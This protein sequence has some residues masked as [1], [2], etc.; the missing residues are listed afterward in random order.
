M[1]FQ[2]LPLIFLSVCILNGLLTF[3]AIPFF[4]SNR[5]SRLYFWVICNILFSIGSATIAIQLI[6]TP[7]LMAFDI[8]NP[9]IAIAQMMR[10]LSVVILAFILRSFLPRASQ[11]ISTIKMFLIILGIIIFSISVTYPNIAAE[12][13]GSILPNLGAVALG[14]WCLYQINLIKKSGL[15]QNSYSLRILWVTACGFVALPFLVLVM[16][17]ITYFNLVPST[18]FSVTDFRSADYVVRILLNIISPAAFIGTLMLWI[19]GY[20][21]LAIQSKADSLRIS[22]LLVEKDILINN[23][24]N[25]NALVETGA[26]SAGLAHEL[27]QFLARIE[28]NGDKALGLIKS[29]DAQPALIEPAIENILNANRSAA[30][31]IKS[32]QI[33]FKGSQRPSSLCNL[34]DLL[35]DVVSIYH[36]RLEKSKIKIEM[37]LQAKEPWV[38]W[39]GLMS[40]V[41]SNLLSN[42][43]DALGAITKTEKLI[44]ITSQIDQYG[45]YRMTLADN[46]LGIDPQHQDKLFHL[47][48][49]S[50]STGSGIGL[51]LSRYI[52]ERHEGALTFENLPERAGVCF[53]LTLPPGKLNSQIPFASLQAKYE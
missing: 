4:S 13:K 3:L 53:I 52:V 26:L 24:A 45:S 20:S 11:R 2:I 22:N 30:K 38:V 14:A 35:L 48:Q 47:F 39:D 51:W 18:H 17:G 27:N 10:S 49:T 43:I 37:D 19:E 6:N 16:A 28:L 44:R 9:A 15:Y 32:L 5:N 12:F 31:V 8:S 23:L 29:P 33:L 41:F 21:D 40:Q 1:N 50:K 46:A 42:S 25:A 36:D 7:G 34:D